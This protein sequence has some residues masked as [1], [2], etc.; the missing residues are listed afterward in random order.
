MRV[1]VP[2]DP[3]DPWSSGLAHLAFNQKITGS[4]PVGF[5]VGCTTLTLILGYAMINASGRGGKMWI[6]FAAGMVAGLM[7][8]WNL[9]SRRWGSA[10]IWGIL[11][12]LMMAT[13]AWLTL[14]SIT[15]P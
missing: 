5:T 1:R 13:F 10:G 14:D 4:N 8:G 11:A 12:L 2:Y 6:V 7:C 3:L 9:G 15:P